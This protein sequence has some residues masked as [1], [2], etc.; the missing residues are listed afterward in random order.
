[1][2][3][4]MMT[5]NPFLFLGAISGFL[6][7][8]FGAFAAH[9]LQDILSP[10]LLKTF[11]TAVEYQATHAL[12]L[13]IVGLLSQPQ[14]YHKSL[15]IAGWAFATGTLLFSGS[16]YILALTSADGMGMV[17]PFGGIA[18]LVGWA[19]LAWS[20]WQAKR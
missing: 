6:S 18:F 11:H 1:M 3:H 13:C 8:L 17:T 10:G 5:N 12:A 2:I 4:P 20:Q 14:G 15:R 19:S 9:A 16:L 7:V